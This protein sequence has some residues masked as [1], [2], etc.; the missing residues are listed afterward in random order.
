MNVLHF[1]LSQI[2]NLVSLIF[3]FESTAPTVAYYVLLDNSRPHK[4]D[5]EP[6]LRFCPRKLWQTLHT[7]TDIWWVICHTYAASLSKTWWQ[8][9]VNI[10]LPVVQLFSFSVSKVSV[11]QSSLFYF[12]QWGPNIHI[13]LIF[14]HICCVIVKVCGTFEMYCDL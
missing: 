6:F 9:V 1:E 10:I 14:K 2:C 4:C 7:I 5:S 8:D 3:I 12:V 11:M 13:V